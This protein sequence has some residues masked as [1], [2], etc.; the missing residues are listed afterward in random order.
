MTTNQIMCVEHSHKVVGNAALVLD[1]NQ[2]FIMLFLRLIFLF[3]VYERSSMIYIIRSERNKTVER[4]YYERNNEDPYAETDT[5]DSKFSLEQINYRKWELKIW[6]IYVS[7]IVLVL[8]FELTGI[9][10]YLSS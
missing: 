1:L 7:I 4:I 5:G 9:V 8:T 10:G 3:E 6:R 2:N